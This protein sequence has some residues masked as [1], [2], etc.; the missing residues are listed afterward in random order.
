MS[1]IAPVLRMFTTAPQPRPIDGCPAALGRPGMG[2]FCTPRAVTYGELGAKRQVGWTGK[3]LE[4]LW[5]VLA[6]HGSLKWCC[7]GTGRKGN[8]LAKKGDALF[9]N[10]LFFMSSHFTVYVN[11]R[12]ISNM[13]TYLNAKYDFMTA[14]GGFSEVL[15]FAFIG[16]C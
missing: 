11:L 5:V 12:V 8:A 4:A 9:Q 1:F 14:E 13:Y 7:S 16:H 15:I 3:G 6:M 2:N 10:S